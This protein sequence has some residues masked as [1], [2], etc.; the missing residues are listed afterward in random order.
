[1]ALQLTVLT[2][3]P[4]EPVSVPSSQSYVIL[5]PSDPLPF[6]GLFRYQTHVVHIC[7]GKTLIHT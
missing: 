5:V 3:L 4:E 7:V 6:P 1:M 2:A